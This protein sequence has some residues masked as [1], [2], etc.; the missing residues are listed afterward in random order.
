LTSEAPAGFQSRRGL[1]YDDSAPVS[2]H[3]APFPTY[4]ATRGHHAARRRGKVVEKTMRRFERRRRGAAPVIHKL[5]GPRLARAVKSWIWRA[6]EWSG[7]QRYLTIFA[8]D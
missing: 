8:L 4:K 5:F 2:P 6:R 3:N 7:R 1:S